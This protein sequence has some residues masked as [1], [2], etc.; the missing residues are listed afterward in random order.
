M[1]QVSIPDF[2]RERG[3]LMRPVLSVNAAKTAVIAIDFQRFFIDAGQP[4]GN[5]PARDILD[6]ANRLHAAVRQAGG[7][8]ILTQ[9]RVGP[10]PRT[11]SAVSVPAAQPS[12]PHEP[13]ARSDTHQLRPAT[14]PPPPHWALAK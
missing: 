2:A 13:L 14:V 8:V 4:M 11:I 3:A 9:H 12:C 7:P 1:H 5:Q 10:P 6:H